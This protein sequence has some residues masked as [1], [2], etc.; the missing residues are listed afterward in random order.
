MDERKI[1]SPSEH[2]LQ[3][4]Y[5]DLARIASIIINSAMAQGSLVKSGSERKYVQNFLKTLEDTV[6]EEGKKTGHDVP[7]SSRK[8]VK[9]FFMEVYNFYNEANQRNLAKD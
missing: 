9:D 3:T 4:E 5:T 7:Y 1:N 2:E 8:R 6:R